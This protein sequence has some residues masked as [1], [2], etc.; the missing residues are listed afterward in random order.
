MI[1]RLLVLE[2][3]MQPISEFSYFLRTGRRLPSRQSVELKFNHW[4]DP[5]NGRFT[6]VGKGKYFGRGAS[7]GSELAG[8]SNSIRFAQFRPNPRVRMGGNGGPPL[9]DPQ[10][11]E[12]VFPSA[13]TAP[14][15]AII[16]LADNILDLSGP[17]HAI[18]TE[19]TMIY[20]NR[21]EREIQSIYPSYIRPSAETDGPATAEGQTNLINR[22]RLDRA[23]AYYRKGEFR[24]YQ[25]ETLRFIQKEVDAAYE[26]GL[27][28]LQS[29]RLAVHLSVELTLGNFVDGQ[30]RNKLRKFHRANGIPTGRNDP[31][32]VNSNA[33]NTP[34]G[35]YTR[36]DSRVGNVAFDVT[37][38]RKTPGTKQIRGFFNSDFKPVAVVIVRPRQLGWKSTYIITRPVER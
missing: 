20:A 15:G 10:T 12:H 26:L 11:L 3:S 8:R 32:Q 35:S 30:V 9:N 4:H 22:L 24:P 18:T 34:E 38:E 1:A 14:G 6:F 2:Q 23:K 33:M 21:L 31:T 28:L 25:V 37:L 19:L 17:A 16:G 5:K 29:G 7:T 36:P 27:K 13:R